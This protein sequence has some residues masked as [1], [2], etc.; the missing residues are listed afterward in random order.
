MQRGEGQR[1][2]MPIGGLWSSTTCG[3]ARGSLFARIRFEVS[4]AT[5]GGA[6]GSLIARMRFEVSPAPFS[7]RK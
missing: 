3:G 2:E 5:C 7:Q 4:P 6:K 1:I